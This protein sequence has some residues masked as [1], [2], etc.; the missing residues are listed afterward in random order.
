MAVT[1][2]TGLVND[3]AGRGR[4]YLILG[5]DISF[6]ETEHRIASASNAFLNS[7]VG[8][9]VQVLGSLGNN[10]T[11]TV[12]AVD[13]GGAFVTVAE[14]ITTESAGTTIAAA[15]FSGGK[16][17]KECLDF[18]V[19]GIFG[20]SRPAT[21]DDDEGGQPLVWI[22]KDGA[23]FVPGNPLNG[24]EFGDSVAGVIS[25][26]G[27]EWSGIPT[28]SGTALWARFYDNDRVMGFS[29]TAK[30]MDVTC[31]FSSGEMR[32]SSTNVVVDK[33][34]IVTTGQL[35]VPKA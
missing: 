28:G 25:K 14:V 10:G 24:L 23:A 31:G 15:N 9:E 2:S 13:P 4:N 22:T 12:T 16:S 34:I 6:D 11:F 8:D 30:R 20:T 19:L 17:L 35:S 26:V 27:D 1:L 3:M 29:T 32:L 5:S 18:G 33:K 7:A 21:A